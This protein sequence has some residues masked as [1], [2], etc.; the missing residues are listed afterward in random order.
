MKHTLF[1]AVALALTS[2]MLYAENDQES[3]AAS[4]PPA[5]TSAAPES[6]VATPPSNAAPAP[7]AAP[8]P[9]PAEKP[10]S[11][12]RE[13]LDQKGKIESIDAEAKI[14]NVA[15]KTFKFIGKVFVS[16]KQHSFSDLKVGDNVAVTYYVKP[17]GSNI[18][19]GVYI[20]KG[21]K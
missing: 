3:S 11:G 8:V 19:T 14:F 10:K 17:D 15:G 20:G 9:A 6:A 12:G 7:Q 13:Y 16:K 18:A 2:S 4:S 5:A 21:K 1:F